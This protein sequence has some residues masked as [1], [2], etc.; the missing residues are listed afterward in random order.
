L[1]LRRSLAQ[2]EIK[3]GDTTTTIGDPELAAALGGLSPEDVR[4]ALRGALA[5][6]PREPESRSEQ[7]S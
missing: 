2:I 3:L 7:A 1:D 5:D 4:L 6:H